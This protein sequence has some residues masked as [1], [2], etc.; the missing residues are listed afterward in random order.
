MIPI[1]VSSIPAII[2]SID[3]D[4]WDDD[5]DSDFYEDNEFDDDF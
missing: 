3:D 2:A 5:L 4:F 1:I